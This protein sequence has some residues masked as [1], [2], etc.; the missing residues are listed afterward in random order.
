MIQKAMK[1]IWRIITGKKGIYCKYGIGNHF[2]NGSFLH[3]STTIGNYNYIGYRVMTEN[4]E[5]GNYNSIASDVKMGQ[6]EHDLHCVSTS[7]KIFGPKHG[8][9]QYDGYI[10]PTCIENDVWIA[11]NAVIK[12]GVTI[13]TGAVIGAGAVVTHDVPAYAIV[14]GVPAKLIRY[15]FDQKTIEQLQNS[16]WW[17]LTP[18]EARVICKEIQNT[19]K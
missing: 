9:T 13:H 14:G 2:C 18:R 19:I 11:A 5:I 16:R 6:M 4:V 7:T 10:Q 15:R 3:E 12:Q 17:S 8:I 1:R